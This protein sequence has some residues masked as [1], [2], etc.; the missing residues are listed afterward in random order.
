MSLEYED[1]LEFNENFR[2]A[3][4]Y[5]G[6][7]KENSIIY[8]RL[9]AGQAWSE[10]EIKDIIED[11]FE[12]LNLNITRR[13]MQFFSGYLRDNINSIIVTSVE[14]SDPKTADQLTKALDYVWDRGRFNDEF[15]DGCDEAGKAGIC[16]LG[17]EL[18]YS[19][20]ILNGDLVAYK[21]TNN[22]F[23]L[24]PLFE[25]LD[26]KDCGF[27]TTRDFITRNDTRRLLSYI[28]GDLEKEIP[29]GYDNFMFPELRP[30]N[31]NAYQQNKVVAY[32]QYYSKRSR[33]RKYLVDEKS[34]FFKDIT[35]LSKD[36]LERLKTGIYRMNIMR[37]EAEFNGM[38]KDDFP[39]MKIVNR[40]SDFIELQVYL[41]GICFYKGIDKVG[42]EDRYPFVPSLCYFEPSLYDPNLRVQGFPAELYSNQRQFNKRHMKIIAQMDKEI[43]TG[44]KY[45]I[46]TV[47]DIDDMRQN[48]S[49]KLI[50]V[51]PEDNPEGLNAVQEIKGGGANPS[52]IEYQKILDDLSL[53]LL[54]VNES[55]LGIDQDSKTI[56]SG[57]LAEIRIAQGMR[58]NRKYFDKIESTQEIYAD[59]LLKAIQINYTPEKIE[60]IIGEKPTDQ[61]Y[62][63]M[64]ENYQIVLQQGIK[65]K[66]QQ[67]ALY[68]EMVNLKREGIVDFS[69]RSLVKALNITGIS[70]VEAEVTE[71]EQQRKV[72]QQKIDMEERIKI[73]LQLATIEEKLG[74][75]IERRA[76]ADSNEGLELSRMA[77]AEQNRS[78]AA[79]ARAKTMTEISKLEDERLF[80]VLEFVNRM[81]KE[82][83]MNIHIDEARNETRVDEISDEVENEEPEKNM[84]QENIPPLG[85]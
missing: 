81:E 7:Q 16:L 78:E 19:T 35:D 22:S 69:Q 18:D 21:R 85:G 74:L 75:A 26:L 84:A 60:M 52:L 68:S 25:R 14:K 67:N 24:D 64:F 6:P 34:G 36:E 71:Q 28:D 40:E 4:D 63:K 20:D 8:T 23:Y 54:N 76:R 73:Q 33:R 66:T 30:S 42:I 10:N 43:S 45:L 31:I 47:P 65:T 9:A 3:K 49:N 50:G 62:S 1:R 15:L 37:D 5:W 57:R 79:L 82:E 2:Y 17:L 58:I 46:G 61:F 13:P 51:D 41:N 48:G 39:V 59:L 53:T 80:R 12:P 72:Q 44:F 70:E 32:D 83:K 77:E 56:I 38:R 29:Y 55:A 27:A 11:G